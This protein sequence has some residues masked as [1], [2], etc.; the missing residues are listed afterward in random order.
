MFR[1]CCAGIASLAFQSDNQ[2]M[3]TNLTQVQDIAYRELGQPPDSLTLN[4]RFMWAHPAHILALGL[5]SGLSPKAPGTVGTLWAWVMFSLLQNQLSELQWGWML[6]LCIVAGWWACT[7]TAKHMHDQDPGCIVWDEI[8]AF[9]LV[10]WLLCPTGL[11]TQLAAFLLFR[12]FDASKI[13]PVGW[14][15]SLF[16]DTDTWSK[17]GWGIM[18]DDLVAAFCTLLVMAVWRVW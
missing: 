6:L 12:F 10:L 5:G 1:C 18:F 13:G 4:V 2:A 14:A 15:E 9:W 8:A 17:A 11:G 7:V 16:H 3:K